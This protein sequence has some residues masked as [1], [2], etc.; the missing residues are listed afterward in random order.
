MTE[1]SAILIFEQ[2]ALHSH[3]S[4]GPIDFVAGPTPRISPAGN[5]LCIH[6]F[7]A[8]LDLYCFIRAI[9]SFG[10]R[11]LF[12]VVMYGLLFAVASLAEEHGL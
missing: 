3:F 1:G 2:R 11:G 8:L 7:L 4:P 12:F 6:L 9:S 10:E 5:Y